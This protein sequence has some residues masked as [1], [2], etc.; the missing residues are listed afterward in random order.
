M[1]IDLTLKA[2]ENGVDKVSILWSGE[3]DKSMIPAFFNG[4]D[5]MASNLGMGPTITKLELE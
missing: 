5:G 4:L 3:A 2:S 1:K